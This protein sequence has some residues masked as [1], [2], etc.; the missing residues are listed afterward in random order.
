[1][2]DQSIVKMTMLGMVQRDRRR[3]RLA[4]RWSN[5]AAGWCASHCQRLSVWRLDETRMSQVHHTDYEFK[6]EEEEL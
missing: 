3:G 5:D 2:K 1:M 6:E 4:R